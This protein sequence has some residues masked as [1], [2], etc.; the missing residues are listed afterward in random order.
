[1]APPHASHDP[2]RPAQAATTTR[3][4]A[5][6]LTD[7][8]T[9]TADRVASELGAQV[10]AMHPLAP[11]P[12]IADRALAAEF[13]LVLPL[14]TP[15]VRRQPRGDLR[16]RDIVLARS[17]VHPRLS[18]T[19]PPHP[20]QPIPRYLHQRRRVSERRPHCT[21]PASTSRPTLSYA[22]G[23]AIPNA[24]ATGYTG[25]TPTRANH[26]NSS[27]LRR[28]GL[29]ARLTYP[30]PR[31]PLH[32]SNLPRTADSTAAPQ[33]ILPPTT[34]VHPGHC[35]ISDPRT[36]KSTARRGVGSEIDGALSRC[37][38]VDGGPKLS[39]RRQGDRPHRM[40]VVGRHAVPFDAVGAT[41]KRGGLGEFEHLVGHVEAVASPV[42]P[43]RWALISALAPASE[44]RS[45]TVSP[46]CGSATA[47]GTLQPSDAD[48]AASGAASA[49]WL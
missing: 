42:G 16:L 47:V 32:P 9:S 12:R 31:P 7:S 27:K 28:P 29:P 1:M 2:P 36:P 25:A 13:P 30:S 23:R 6:F 41:P 15:Q 22:V 26:S 38:Y 45:S 24:R 49:S 35:S 20:P 21:P 17:R 46:G 14:P 33:P 19:R 10:R 4:R 18:L 48:T 43:T 37:R 5:R 39:R 44:P 40:P 11:S 8:S 3:N 34:R